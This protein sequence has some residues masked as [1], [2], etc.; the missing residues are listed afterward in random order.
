MTAVIE[1]FE[2]NSD[3]FRIIDDFL[4]FSVAGIDVEIP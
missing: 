1:Y 3:L 2:I 4:S